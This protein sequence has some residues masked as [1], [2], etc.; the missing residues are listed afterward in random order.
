MIALHN[1]RVDFIN[2][3]SIDLLPYCLRFIHKSNATIAELVSELGSVLMTSATM[4][5]KAS[6]DSFISGVLIVEKKLTDHV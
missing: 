4:G 3:R 1:E 5:T 6:S 2:N